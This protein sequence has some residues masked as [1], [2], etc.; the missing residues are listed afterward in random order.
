MPSRR[1]NSRRP[2]QVKRQ[3]RHV[4]SRRKPKAHLLI[5]ECDSE[6]LAA[7]GLNL[8]TPFGQALKTAFP[9]KRIAIVQTSC[10]Q[11]LVQDLADVFQQ[12]GCFRAILIVGHSN[13]T[14]LALTSDG[15]R[16][17]SAVGS[18]FN[19]FEPELCFLAACDAGKSHSVRD[20]FSSIKTL[21]QIYAS[22][23]A[24]NGIQASPLA[25]LIALLLEHGSIDQ[26]DS[27]QLRI[28]SY[29]VT[30]GQLYLWKRR[31]TGPGTVF[32]S[33]LT[34]YVATLLDGGLRDLLN[35]L[36]PTDRSGSVS[37]V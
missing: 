25:I 29:F 32:K 2:R 26:N 36:F 8:G 17:W 22:P 30:R 35:R 37:V 3:R 12:Y 23:C 27:D 10:E 5:I 18:W 15:Q 16:S 34:D 4:K 31:E 9:K 13:E 24:L 1:K 19:K 6:N 28:L 7:S 20:V 21:R 14:G 33:I 11:K